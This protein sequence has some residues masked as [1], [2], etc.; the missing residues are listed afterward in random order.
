M[1]TIRFKDNTAKYVSHEQATKVYQVLIG[2]EQPENE[3][4]AAFIRTVESVEFPQLEMPQRV[5]R[6]GPD[7][8][9]VRERRRKIREILL[10]P[11]IRGKDKYYAIGEVLYGHNIAP[12]QDQQQLV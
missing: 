7:E 8:E 11:T 3:K 9:T 4:Q 2:N 6:S 10:D 5:K 12:R 1:A